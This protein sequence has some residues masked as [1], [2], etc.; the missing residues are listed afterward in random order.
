MDVALRLCLCENAGNQDKDKGPQMTKKLTA[1][2]GAIALSAISGSA[3]AQN[4]PWVEPRPAGMTDQH[5]IFAEEARKAH[6]AAGL[7]KFGFDP[8]KAEWDYQENR[9]PTMPVSN[10]SVAKLTSLLNGRYFTYDNQN[11]GWSVMYFAPNGTT[12]FCASAPDGSYNEWQADRYVASTPFG[13]A[14]MLHWDP[15]RNG[16][17]KPPVLETKGYPFVADPNTGFVSSPRRVSYGWQAQPG[18]LQDEYATAFSEKCRD[19]P[20][21]AKINYDQ[22]GATVEDLAPPAKPIKGFKVDFRSDPLAPLTAGMYYHQ[23]PPK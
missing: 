3:V 6:L 5:V 12:H 20:R 7:D 23:F 21:A 19:L 11:P 13:L 10:M 17:D 8:L 18:W 14:G 15:K 2:I 16:S 4:E 9:L 1:I 22:E